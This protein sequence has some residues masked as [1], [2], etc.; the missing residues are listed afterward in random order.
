MMNSKVN[1]LGL[2]RASIYIYIY[3]NVSSSSREL[4]KIKGGRGNLPG[5]RAS[6]AV[7]ATVRTTQ[8]MAVQMSR[9]DDV[10]EDEQEREEDVAILAL[11]HRLALH[12]TPTTPLLHASS[13]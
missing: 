10:V 3:I 6:A 11:F 7:S 9:I 13:S 12:T 8:T 2:E 4:I 5:A 1:E